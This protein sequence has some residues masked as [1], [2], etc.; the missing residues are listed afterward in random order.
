MTTEKTCDVLIVGGAIIGS[1]VA[2]FLA[3]ESRGRLRVTVVERDPS[4]QYCSTGRSLASIRVQFSCPENVA[5]SQFGVA[6]IKTAPQA[7]AVDGDRPDLSFRENGYLVL[8]DR[9]DRKVLEENHR[10]Q[11]AAGAD[12]VL[13]EPEDLLQRF[14]W[15][16]PEGVAL[17]S[18]GVSGEGWFDAYA[19]MSAF[20]RKAQSLGVTYLHDE[21]TALE[22][23]GDRVVSASL[24]GG[25]RLAF[26]HL[27]N[28]AGPNAGKLAAMVGIDLP[29]FPRKRNV[30]VIDCR[31]TVAR[32]PLLID[33][34]GVFCRPE[35]PSFVCGWSP[36]EPDDPD[37]EDLEIEWGLF[38][39]RVWPAL[40][41]RVPA[42]EAVKLINAWAGHYAVN[43][44]DHNAILGPHPNLGNFILANGFSGHGVQQSPAVG[45]GI[46]ELL[47]HGGYRALDLGGFGFERFATGRLIQERNVF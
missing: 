24:A 45:R 20:R 12:V 36:P 37:C 46:A 9:H 31:E 10:V 35:G 34:G 5:I 1:A 21:V 22:T 29:V 43:P 28:A 8:A 25:G 33:T 39:E 47:V 4:Y 41:R 3:L 19:L 38:E 6:F 2:Y 42:F 40:A 27:V 15:I 23:A 32:F 44:L 7:L 26:D 16:D 17:G 14:P 11:R 18:F 30:F 13:I